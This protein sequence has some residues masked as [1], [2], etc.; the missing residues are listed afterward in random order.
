[1]QSSRKASVAG[2]FIPSHQQKLIHHEWQAACIGIIFAE[3]SRH[4]VSTLAGEAYLCPVLCC[5]QC[6]QDGLA[7]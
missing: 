2:F 1:M 6:G 5:A 4:L 3:A 7:D